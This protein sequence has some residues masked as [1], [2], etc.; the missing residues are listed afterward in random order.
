[1]HYILPSRKN[2]HFST[3]LPYGLKR[4]C[5]LL[6]ILISFL[7]I[8]TTPN[9]AFAG[10]SDLVI[11]LDL[12]GS[13]SASDLNLEKEATRSLLR[14]FA[15]LTP[16]PRVAIGSFNVR[17][18]KATSPTDA[19]RI[20]PGGDLTSE[21]GSESAGTGLFGA[22]NTIVNPQGYT[23][24]GA[25]ITVAQT[26]LEN[27]NSTGARFIILISDGTSNRPGPATYSG[28]DPCG[29]S[30]AQ[31]AAS[32]AATDAKV[33]GTAIVGVHYV[34]NAFNSTCPNEPA[35][36]F[37]FLKNSIVSSESLFLNGTGNL[38]SIFSRISCTVKCDDGNS[39]TTETCNATTGACESTPSTSDI[40]GDTIIDCQDTCKGDDRLLGGSCVSTT[41]TTTGATDCK[42]SGIY[43][44]SS[45]GA[46][47]CAPIN[48]AAPL[49]SGCT[50]SDYSSQL[51]ELESS[52]NLAARY[53]QRAAKNLK[54]SAQSKNALKLY[55]SEIGFGKKAKVL[56]KNNKTILAAIP[57][58]FVTCTA[59]T[60]CSTVFQDLKYQNLQSEA[61]FYATSLKKIQGALKKLNGG[62]LA[63]ADAKAKKAL[64][65][66]VKD[67]K[68]LVSQ[69]P[70][71]HSQ[72]Q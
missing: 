44:C 36:G 56:A 2:Q 54:K 69:L 10:D 8:Q 62:K 49:C 58:T 71:T 12:T 68:R 13:T 35:A 4:I 26:H 5:L 60:Q 6:G 72:C 46:V 30:N 16:K 21:Y 65:K 39:C 28:C 57:Q 50:S 9:I 15:A 17:D 32:I 48:G 24:I 11:M 55:A 34:G 37:N 66:A 38:E 64:G 22:I 67:I 63:S 19:A 51:A 20:V 25:A 14:Y 1:M 47:A 31:A 45:Q 52:R 59:Q 42:T 53:V 7:G 70:Q 18:G 23:D 43:S 40:D 61:D 29:C 3:K 33:K 41:T 27:Q